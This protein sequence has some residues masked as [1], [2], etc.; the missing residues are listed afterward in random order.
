MIDLRN[1]PLILVSALAGA[2]LMAMFSPAELPEPAE[3]ATAV[4]RDGD[5]AAD[6]PVASINAG[7]ITNAAV[8]RREA[9]GHYWALATIGR[10]HAKFMIDTGAST[11]AL[12]Y[13]D[14]RRLGLDP[15]NLDF[16]WNI[17][18]AGGQTK[19]ASVLLPSIR[20]GNVEV[21]NVEAMVLGPELE[22]SLL[23][24]TFLSELYSY[25]FR[26]NSLII[27]Q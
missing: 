13:E 12:T 27:R 5:V 16:R 22:Q 26:Q 23:G 1:A 15:D 25:E 7:V 24:M 10:S 6:E 21:E 17:A 3:Q 19:G 2:F 11:V 9:D 20:I 8:L 4:E 18:T 14:A